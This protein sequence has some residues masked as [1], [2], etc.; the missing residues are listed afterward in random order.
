M[1]LINQT[2][3]PC[4]GLNLTLAIPLYGGK[5]KPLQEVKPNPW[6]GLDLKKAPNTSGALT[7]I[8]LMLNLYVIANGVAK[9][10]RS[11]VS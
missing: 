5:S 4:R 2:P 10:T 8:K 11:T 6:L 7:C 9:P 1:A 3:N